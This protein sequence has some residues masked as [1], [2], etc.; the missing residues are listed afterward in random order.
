[1]AQYQRVFLWLLLYTVMI[2]AGVGYADK[3]YL[4][5]GTVQESERVWQ[6]QLHVHFILQGTQGVVIR[7]AKEIVSRVVIDGIGERV[8]S[9]PHHDMGSATKNAVVPKSTIDAAISNKKTLIEIKT[10]TQPKITDSTIARTLKGI[11]FY[12]PKREQRYWAAKDSKH[13]TLSDALSALAETYS[14]SVQWVENHMGAENDLGVI[15]RNLSMHQNNALQQAPKKAVTQPVAPDGQFYTKTKAAPYSIGDGRTFKKQAEAVKAL[16]QKYGRSSAW[17]HLYLGESNDLKIIHSN[18]TKASHQPAQQV[19][20]EG[21]FDNRPR[22]DDGTAPAPNRLTFYNPRRTEKYWI[23]HTQR[24]NAL[25][26]ALHALAQQYG[27]TIEW[28][29]QHMGSTNDLA[30]IHQNIKESLK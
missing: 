16:A 19:E 13:S 15:H 29:D 11:S 9:E 24:Y 5:D 26:D 7:Y 17:V 25:E 14:Q 28:I 3:I 21:A 20:A 22:L 30:L 10:P 8:V 18:L 12:D 6:S 27:V 23:S 2:S 4:K 1:M